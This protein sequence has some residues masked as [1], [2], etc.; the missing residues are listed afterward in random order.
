MT[1][2]LL[3]PLTLPSLLLSLTLILLQMAT[4]TTRGTQRQALVVT[5]IELL[6]TEGHPPWKNDYSVF[7]STF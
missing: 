5:G 6:T 4:Y 3:K 7:L 2:N 1:G